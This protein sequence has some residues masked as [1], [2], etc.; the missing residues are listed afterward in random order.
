MVDPLEART[1]R[2]SRA[3]TSSSPPG[4]ARDRGAGARGRRHRG[5]LDRHRRR[6]GP[7]DD[8]PARLRHRRLR[9]RGRGGYRFTHVSNYHAGLVIRSALFR[10]PVR[11]D[12]D[13]DPAGHL[14]GSGTRLGRA[15]GGGGAAHA[16]APSGS[17]A[18]PFARTTA[19]RRNARP[20]G[21]VKAIVTAAGP[22]PRLRHRRAAARANSSCPGPSPSR[23]PQG[24]GPRRP[25]LPL[26]DPLRS[27]EAGGGGIPAAVGAESLAAPPH[28]PRAPLRVDASMNARAAAV[29]VATSL[30]G[31]FGL[32]ARLLAAH[33]P[34]RD[35]GGGADLRSLG[36]EFPP[37]LA[38]RPARRGA[39]RRPRAR[40][41][42]RGAPVGRPRGAAARRR[43]RPGR[44]P[45]AAAGAGFCSHPTTM[46]PEV[47]EDRGSA[48]RATWCLPDR[49]RPRVAVRA[50]PTARSG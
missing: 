45:C 18:G 27:D 14:H 34:V 33:D 30:A 24:A 3:A 39:D 37:Q 13:A 50:R 42:P 4:A 20:E 36:R 15:L 21:H 41:G 7:A 47:D 5:R 44:S 10:L 49:G 9:R 28:R 12:S 32:S 11:V 29:P 48:R 25:R 1:A 35:A 40:R 31:R 2:S 8:Q 17:C 19:R 38:E 23:G 22:D 26:S 46:P 6:Q 16:T 43:G